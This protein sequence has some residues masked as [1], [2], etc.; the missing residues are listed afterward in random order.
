MEKTMYE[1]GFNTWNK[2][3]EI[4]MTLFTTSIKTAN[5]DVYSTIKTLY[6]AISAISIPIATVFFL[7]A[8]LRE[9]VSAPPEQQSKKLLA[10]ALKY[11]IMIGI[12]ANL[13]TIM[14]VVIDVADG[15]TTALSNGSKVA[16][17]GYKMEMSSDLVEAINKINEIPWY[18][19][20]YWH[21]GVFVSAFITL[22]II[23]GSCVSILSCAFQRIIKPLAILP[24]AAITVAMGAGSGSASRVASQY[25]KTFI[26]FL[27]SGAFMVI[28]VKLGVGLSK[29]MIAFNVNDLSAKEA[30]IYIS[31]QYSIAPI[32]IAGLIKSTD[33]IIGK[34]L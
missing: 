28:C 22:L 25:M 12:L 7:I 2:L 26:G 13:W 16:A 32:M 24:F 29:G 27:L 17:A 31:I 10:S 18:E 14:G 5:G 6:N 11:G 1:A 20:W 33:S 8:I 23:V 21:I 9:V 4:A 15:V 34:F 19:E 30:V 3:I